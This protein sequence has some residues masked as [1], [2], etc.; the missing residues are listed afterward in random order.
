MVYE[1]AGEM[2]ASGPGIVHPHFYI[3]IVILTYLRAYF[4]Y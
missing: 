1:A 2:P 3:A 4:E